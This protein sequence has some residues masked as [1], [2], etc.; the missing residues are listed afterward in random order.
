MRVREDSNKRLYNHKLNL[1]IMK[2]FTDREKYC[3]S[4]LIA[5]GGI[6]N[7]YDLRDIVLEHNEGFSNVKH[8]GKAVRR[9]IDKLIERGELEEK[10]SMIEV[11]PVT[12]SGFIRIFYSDILKALKHY[13]NYRIDNIMEFN[14]KDTLHFIDDEAFYEYYF[15]IKEIRG[16]YNIYQNTKKY[17]AVITSCGICVEHMVN[18]INEFYNFN[19][20]ARSMQSLINKMKNS[21]YIQKMDHEE[22]DK[23]MHFLDGCKLIY[24]YRNE[25]GA[26]TTFSYGDELIAH[27]GLIMT[28]YLVEHFLIDFC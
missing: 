5:N 20:K 2:T 16:A 28:F 12:E 17:N 23:W 13:H 8:V 3:I 7:Y 1:K 26:H 22:K 9:T 21:E 25:M 4:L 18:S 14:T 24:Q 6:M 15:L 27:S 11:S 19:L 10:D